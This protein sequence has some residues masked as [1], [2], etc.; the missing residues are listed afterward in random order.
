[1]ASMGILGGVV[2]IM[3]ERKEDARSAVDA[4][5][6]EGSRFEA[7]ADPAERLS[8]MWTAIEE[9]LR[10]EKVIRKEPDGGGC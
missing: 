5:R 10:E 7:E 2:L 3:T 4:S 9:K 8:R 6:A 1:M